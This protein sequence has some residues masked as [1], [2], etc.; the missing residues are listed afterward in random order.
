M[1]FGM[2]LDKPDIR[3]VVHF[4]LPKSLESLGSGLQLKN[5]GLRWTTPTGEPQEYIDIYIYKIH[6]YIYV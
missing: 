3:T 5:R 2:G 1:A 6:I 4:G